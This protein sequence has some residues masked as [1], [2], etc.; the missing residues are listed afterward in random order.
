MDFVFLFIRGQHI[1]GFDIL[2]KHQ[3]LVYQ[4]NQLSVCIISILS[5]PTTQNARKK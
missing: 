1:L 3:G 4:T 2:Q 5:V